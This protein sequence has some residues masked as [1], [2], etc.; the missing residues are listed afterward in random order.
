MCILLT[1]FTF[2]Y[3]KYFFNSINLVLCGYVCIIFVVSKKIS[4]YVNTYV[5]LYNKRACLHLSLTATRT[6]GHHSNMCIYKHL[7][8]LRINFFFDFYCYTYS[9]IGI[10]Y[11]K[12]SKWLLTKM[13]R[14]WKYELFIRGLKRSIQWL[15]IL[16][17]NSEVFCQ[18][19]YTEGTN[20][21]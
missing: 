17:L 12:Q 10:I 4:T 18:K 3:N 1:I 9:C 20:S 5:L 13:H 21:F 19:W 7:N 6:I 11:L 14:E 8:S 2:V 16:T 15:L